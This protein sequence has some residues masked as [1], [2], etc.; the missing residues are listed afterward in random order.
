MAGRS[1][2]AVLALITAA[3]A[4]AAYHVP[5]SFMKPGWQ[6]IL[7]QVVAIALALILG[8]MVASWGPRPTGLLSFQ[9]MVVVAIIL[10]GFGLRL[11]LRKQS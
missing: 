4:L 8:S 9:E 5:V 3:A 6:R 7:A 1:M 11:F 2:L 10:L